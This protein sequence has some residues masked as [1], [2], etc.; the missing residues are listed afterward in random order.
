MSLLK[1]TPSTVEITRQQQYFY[2][3]A[4]DIGSIQNFTTAVSVEKHLCD[5]K[6]FKYQ[7]IV[8]GS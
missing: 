3:R 1:N 4:K 7:Q 8:S 6:I 5:I 2:A